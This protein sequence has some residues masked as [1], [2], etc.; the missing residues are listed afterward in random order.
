MKT[1]IK[2]ASILCLY[3]LIPLTGI[4]Q[5][6]N[7]YHLFN[8]TPDSLLRP[9]TTDRP[10]ITETPYTVDAGRFQFEFDLFNIFRHPIEGGKKE[11][12]FLFLNGFLKAGLTHRSEIQ[13]QLSAWQ[14]H[15]PQLKD[16]G[17]EKMYQGFGDIGARYKYNLK[18]NDV[19]GLALA[20]MPSLMV[21][22]RNRASEGYY[23][24]GVN[25]IWG[26]EFANDLEIGGQAEYH[27]LFNENFELSADEI[28]MVALIGI[29]LGNRFEWFVE[30]ANIFSNTNRP[31]PLLNTGIIYEVNANFLLDFA[32]QYGLNRH[33]H[34]SIFLGF[35]YRL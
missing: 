11:T 4:T 16:K 6:K 30:S 29:P 17:D 1:I 18:G 32:F 25:F 34:E 7:K 10:D 20:I 15:F 5:N 19:D 14:M 31:R 13:I 21:P 12:D 23:V 24:P 33:A 2:I 22:L 27:V 8:R 3:V 28:W 26:K 9:M 35:S